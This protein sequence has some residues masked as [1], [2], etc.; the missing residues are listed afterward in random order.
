MELE[1][2][3]YPEQY[4]QMREFTK[5][6]VMHILHEDG[7]YRHLRFQKPGTGIYH[8]DIITW[9]GSLVIRGDVGEG[10]VFTRELDML[11]W[12]DHGQAIG[13][14]NA[15][16]WSE[17]LDLGRNSVKEFSEKKFIAWLDQLSED[18][19]YVDRDFVERWSP[20][21]SDLDEAIEFCAEHGIEWDSD[22][23]ENWTDY[24]YHF[25]LALHCIL[26]GAQIYNKSREK[27]NDR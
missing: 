14:I 15:H 8:F 17:K 1:W 23:P 4:K 13:H 16:Y 26:W 11:R 2:Y 7:N 24:N 22:D 3:Y 25:I 19:I 18:G 6:H 20:S 12:F 5:D 21:V 9:P 10:Y 27:V